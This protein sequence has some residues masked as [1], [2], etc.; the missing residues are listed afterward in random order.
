MRKNYIPEKDVDD[1]VLQRIIGSRWLPALKISSII[2]EKKIIT[3]EDLISDDNIK[4]DSPYHVLY[5]LQKIGAV[6]HYRIFREFQNHKVVY[7][8]THDFPNGLTLS[9]QIKFL[10]PYQKEVINRFLDYGIKIP[11]KKVFRDWL[12]NE[13]PIV[14]RIFHLGLNSKNLPHSN[15]IHILHF[16]D[17]SQRLKVSRTSV[18]CALKTLHDFGA[19]DRYPWFK[20]SYYFQIKGSNSIP[21][22]DNPFLPK[23]IQKTLKEIEQVSNICFRDLAHLREKMTGKWRGA[24]QIY[25]ILSNYEESFSTGL[26]LEDLKRILINNNIILKHRQSLGSLIKP[27]KDIGVLFTYKNGRHIFYQLRY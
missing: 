14:L 26:S 10:K 12:G 11:N 13:W 19:L 5:S 9:D 25:R 23:D 2:N 1:K 15:N 22:T 17:L 24:L 7:F 16:K 6:N 27:L 20:R 8:F 4:T 3:I 21:L 18:T